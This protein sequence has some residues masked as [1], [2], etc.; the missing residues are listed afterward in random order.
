MQILLMFLKETEERYNFMQKFIQ[1]HNK[2]T[3][4]ERVLKKNLLKNHT[5]LEALGELWDNSK[6]LIMN[7]A[8]N[9]KNKKKG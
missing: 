2:I 9:N 3:Y 7:E 8:L 4:C 5:R 1:K 6:K